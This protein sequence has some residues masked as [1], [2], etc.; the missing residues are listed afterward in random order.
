MKILITGAN[1]MLGSMLKELCYEKGYDVIAT[2]RTELDITN[3][4][5]VKNKLEQERPDW[6]VNCAAYTNVEKAEDE[7]TEI[8]NLINGDAPGLLAEL[9][10]D[11]GIGFIHISTDYVFSDNNQSGHFESDEPGDRQFNKYAYA[12]RVGEVKALDNNPNTYLIRTSWVFGPNGKNFVDIMLTLSETRSELSIVDDEI[13]IPTYTKDISKSIIYVMEHKN[14]LQ[15]G[16]Y[17]AVS[18]GACSRLDQARAVFEITKKD[19]KL[20]PMKVADYPRKAKVPNYSILLNTKLPKIQDWREAIKE[21]IE[22][23][24]V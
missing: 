4:E 2:D 21:Y 14:N 5:E 24:K 20:N 22:S 23:K 19:M 12:K 16:V 1:G 7:D 9:T 8:N 10:K 15:P 13:G 18:E 17:H 11:L 6:L 3:K